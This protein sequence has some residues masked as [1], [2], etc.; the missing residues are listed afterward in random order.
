MMKENV[1]GGRGLAEHAA[2]LYD[3]ILH[4][5]HKTISASG[6]RAQMLMCPTCD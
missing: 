1:D 3:C 4:A 5:F 6:K 2:F